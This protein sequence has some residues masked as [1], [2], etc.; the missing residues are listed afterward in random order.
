MNLLNSSSLPDIDA[1]YEGKEIKEESD[2]SYTCPVCQ[3]SYKRKGAADKHLEKQEC[4]STHDVF[5]NTMYEERA[6]LFYKEILV[7]S[8]NTKARPTMKSF[9]KSRLYKPV[10]TYV[11]SC[12]INEVDAGL[13]FSY[14]EEI[15]GFKYTTAILSNGKDLEWIGKYR[16]FL[17]N[18]PSISNSEAFY[19]THKDELVSDPDVLIQS[20]QKAHISIGFITKRKSLEAAVESLPIGYRL[21]LIDIMDKMAEASH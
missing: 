10:V 2:S 1:L 3:K 21:R 7:S 9:R 20:I 8:G 11:V 18:N 5:Q 16:L 19:D 15:I 6:F 13:M 14:L 17:H 4:H 12:I